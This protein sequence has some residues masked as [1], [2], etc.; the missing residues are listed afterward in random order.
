MSFI[1]I[2]V[3]AA[4]VSFLA[5]CVAAHELDRAIAA[6]LKRQKKSWKRNKNRPAF[7]LKA[8][9]V[10]TTLVTLACAVCSLRFVIPDY[11]FWLTYITGGLIGFIALMVHFHLL[12][13]ISPSDTQ[14][15]V[16]AKSLYDLLVAAVFVFA[17]ISAASLMP[18]IARF[19]IWIILLVGGIG[20]V[21][22][23][24]QAS[25]SL[26]RPEPARKPDYEE[27]EDDLI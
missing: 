13:K 21:S 24:N 1:I 23:A 9:L 3:V 6:A 15:E 27:E 4:A 14:G 5:S 7:L 19:V 11:P 18:E 17:L 2:V 10:P 25:R 26:N 22:Y 20:I 12:S 8:Y 16:V